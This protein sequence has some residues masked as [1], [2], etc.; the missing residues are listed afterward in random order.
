MY[1]SIAQIEIANA[2]ADRDK[3][4]ASINADMKKNINYEQQVTHRLAI[5][6]SAD[7]KMSEINM[8]GNF[9][10]AQFYSHL[11]LQPQ[12]GKQKKLND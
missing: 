11:D 5:K 4:I 2:Q 6:T 12:G 3:N 8:Q 7:V 9:A 10:L 1:T